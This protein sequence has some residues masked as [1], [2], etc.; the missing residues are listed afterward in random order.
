MTSR[1]TLVRGLWTLF[2]PLHA[3][4]YFSAES[5][6]AF[7]SVGLTRYWDGYFAGRSA[8]LG[9]VTAAPVTA[10]FSGF[11]PALVERALPAAWS[12]A[13]PAAVLDARSEGAASTLRTLVP[14]PDV[15][16]RA[17]AALAPIAAGADTV[18]RPLAA[19]NRALPPTGD[20]YRDLWQATATLREHRGD[21][22]V[23]ALVTEDIAG[24]TTIVLR[25]GLD[26]DTSSM[27]RSRGWSDEVWDDEQSSLVDRGLL[28]SDGRIT[29]AGAEAIDRAERLTNRLA[30]APWAGLSDTRLIAIAEALA[31]LANACAPLYPQPNPIGMPSPWDAAADPAGATIA[32]GPT[33]R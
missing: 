2:E 33:A 29:P 25:S 30:A 27:K 20:P 3:V 22:H 19:A 21:G 26:L 18:G 9:A 6:A 24:L 32:A 28:D 14:D 31:P 17:L 7:A 23:I 16:A 4:T 1:D 8:P 13:S 11:A 15:A 12:V 10:L 5:R